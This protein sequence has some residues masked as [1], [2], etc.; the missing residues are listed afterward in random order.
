MVL[1]LVVNTAGGVMNWVFF[2]V[3]E[4]RVT[5]LVFLIVDVRPSVEVVIIVTTGAEVIL[6][7]TV[8]VY[9]V[10]AWIPTVR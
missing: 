1:V 3:A 4:G 8:G 9:V 2:A 5:I 10:V 7:V 6:K